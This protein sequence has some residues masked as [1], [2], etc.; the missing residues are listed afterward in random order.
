MFRLLLEPLIDHILLR[1]EDIGQEQF[2]SIPVHI[3]RLINRNFHARLVVSPQIHQNLVLDAP[4]RVRGE[5]DLFLRI[6]RVDRL[7]EADRPNRDQILHTDSCIVKFLCNIHD[8][9][10]IVFDQLA[11]CRL[12][13]RIGKP[14]NRI[15]LLLSFQRRRENICAPDIKNFPCLTKYSRHGP[16]QHTKPESVWQC[17][18]QHTSFLLSFHEIWM[19]NYFIAPGR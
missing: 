19:Q 16:R 7:D 5:L 8:K 15:G 2:I 12:V 1:S 3:E 9:A 17:S 18:L 11:P 4:G 6:E 13:F 14:R 10:Q